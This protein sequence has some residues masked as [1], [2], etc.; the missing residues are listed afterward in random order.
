MDLGIKIGTLQKL[1]LEKAG[2]AASQAFI[3]KSLESSNAYVRG[4]ALDALANFNPDIRL[5]FSDQ[6]TRI[7]TDAKESRENRSKAEAALSAK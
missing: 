7:A 4:A 1:G 2:D 3:A 5:N 6:L